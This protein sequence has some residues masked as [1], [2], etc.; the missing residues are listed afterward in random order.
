MDLLSTHVSFFLIIYSHNVLLCFSQTV[1]A[2]HVK[3]TKAGVARVDTDIANVT[4]GEAYQGY[5]AEQ[6][7]PYCGKTFHRRSRFIRHLNYHLGNRSFLV[8]HSTSCWILSY[9][10]YRIFR[11]K[12]CGLVI[13]C[14][15]DYLICGHNLCPLTFSLQQCKICNKSFVEKSG[16]DAHHLTHQPL[17][18]PCAECGKVFKTP[19]TMK[20]HMRTHLNFTLACEVCKKVFRHEE[21]LRLHK[22]VHREGGLSRQ[23]LVLTCK[24]QKDFEKSNIIQ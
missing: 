15:S 11:T 2:S 6:G 12:V 18:T 21:S 17:N 22:A 16:L 24:M 19:R 14:I 10:L 1:T 9:S 7:C 13:F 5:R 23:H 8:S 4:E 20:R 3:D